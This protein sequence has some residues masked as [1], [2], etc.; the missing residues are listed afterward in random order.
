M[1]H[2]GRKLIAQAFPG[3]RGHDDAEVV[4]GKNVVDD[5]FLVVKKG[6]IAEKMLEGFPG[7][8]MTW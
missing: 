1:A 3:S 7:I 6:I 4:P 5:T 2:Q 8:G